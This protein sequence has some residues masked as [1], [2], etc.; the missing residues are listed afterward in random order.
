MLFTSQ[1]GGDVV[2]VPSASTCA[3]NIGTGVN[4]F[5][6]HGADD[7]NESVHLLIESKFVWVHIVIVDY[8]R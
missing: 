3:H 7:G 1:L 5:L 6:C 2:F 4:L 8:F